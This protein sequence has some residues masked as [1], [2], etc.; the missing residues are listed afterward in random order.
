MEAIRE[1][2]SGADSI[3]GLTDPRN[4]FLEER[5]QGAS[6]TRELYRP[7]IS[8]TEEELGAIPAVLYTCE[9]HGC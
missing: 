3:D 8:H 1:E 7:S 9:H 6:G 2:A 4:R 5:L